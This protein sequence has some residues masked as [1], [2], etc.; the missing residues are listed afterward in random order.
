M[1]VTQSKF[2]ASL[3]R[4]RALVR[5]PREGLFG[6]HSCTW[7]VARET[8]IFLAAG[9]AA[10]LQ[11][12]HPFVAH[13]VDQHSATRTDP[14]GRFLRT[15]ENV[16]PMVFGDL[17]SAFACAR[18]VHKIHQT[19]VGRVTENVGGLR[20]GDPYYANQEAALFWVAATLLDSAILARELL[21]GP[22]SP[23]FKEQY[24]QEHRR[25]VYLFG[26]SDEIIPPTWGDFQRYNRILWS[27]PLL[28]PGRVARD[29]AGF[30]MTPP[31]PL[32]VLPT[33]AY[34]ALTIALLPE[35]I[36][37]GFGL[38]L[39]ITNRLLANATLAAARRTYPQLPPSVR[40]LPAYRDAVRRVEHRPRGRIA[41]LLERRLRTAAETRLRK[42]LQRPR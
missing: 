9:R 23:S 25:F 24:Y 13:A 4:V 26:V 12:A 14:A 42:A 10:L 7:L 2:E 3:E 1:S 38:K 18:R 8:G 35:P 22:L 32:L 34:G 15:F 29:L 40:F 39:D 17:E 11:L 41:A 19:V 31:G 36:R 16:F 28:Q 20:V 33:R 37:E 27:S 6:P 30:L 21:L 5:N